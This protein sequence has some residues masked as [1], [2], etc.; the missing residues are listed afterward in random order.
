MP[1]RSLAS[2]AA[3]ALS[4]LSSDSRAGVI[5]NWMPCVI[6]VLSARR[7]LGTSIL[8]NFVSGFAG[9][10]LAT[11]CSEPSVGT[12][13]PFVQWRAPFE[14]FAVFGVVGLAAAYV[15]IGVVPRLAVLLRRP[16]RWN[17]RVRRALL[18]PLLA[19]R[20]H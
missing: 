4:R 12:A 3:A 2:L 15:V 19:R 7:G 13:V 5:F 9:H 6:S 10:L 16:G 18:I 20:R 14:P 17:L 1:N 11:P 8:A